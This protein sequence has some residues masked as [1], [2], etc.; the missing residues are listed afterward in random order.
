[1]SVIDGMFE[2]EQQPMGGMDGRG[3]GGD[4]G[5]DGDT[6]DDILPGLE[7]ADVVGVVLVIHLLQDGRHAG[8]VVALP[9]RR[10]HMTSG[11]HSIPFPVFLLVLKKMPLRIV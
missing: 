10:S 8:E 7:G 3:D 4:G 5:G 6:Y 11:E 9:Q 2:D 1:M